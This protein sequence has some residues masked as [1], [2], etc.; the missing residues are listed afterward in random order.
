MI[1]IRDDLPWS[2]LSSEA[3]ARQRGEVIDRPAHV[4]RSG[5][6]VDADR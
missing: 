3:L 1:A 5:R 6:D 2:T 4:G